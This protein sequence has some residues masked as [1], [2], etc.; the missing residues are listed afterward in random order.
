MKNKKGFTLVELLSVI[1][2]L[3]IL[4][5]IAIPNVIKMFR[6]AKRDSFES[7]L[8]KIAQI[9]ENTWMSN[10][11]YSQ[12][13]VEYARS[14]GIDCPS[15]LDLTGRTNID[16]YIQINT[17]G[18]IVKYYA[19]DGNYVYKSDTYGLNINDIGGIEEINDNNKI[20]ISCSESIIP[21]PP[22]NTSTPVSDNPLVTYNFTGL[23]DMR[24]WRYNLPETFTVDYNSKN[25]MN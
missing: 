22:N 1:A 12:V 3:A 20:E 23:N 2:I 8:K 11:L 18:K 21:N 19:T 14:G 9:A 13:D 24:L 4:V 16:Y 25:K 15:S 6:N 7:E 17:G 5:I 10:S